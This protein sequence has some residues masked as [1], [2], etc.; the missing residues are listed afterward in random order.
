MQKKIFAVLLFLAATIFSFGS[1]VEKVRFNEYPPQMVFDLSEDAPVYS[2]DY[3]EYNRLLFLDIGNN[4]S[5]KDKN[6]RNGLPKYIEKVQ[7]VD[8]GTSSGYFVTLNKNIFHKVSL[9]KNPNR[10]V[11]D[12]SKNAQNKQYT[13]V[14]DP[15]HGGK[16]PGAIG[17]GGTKEKDIAL[18]VGKYLRDELKKDFNVVMTRDSDEF[19]TL[20]NR[21]KISNGIGADLFISVHINSAEN[22]KLSGMEIFYFS[23]K[24]SPYA[25]RIAEFENSVGA[26]Y[27]EDA[28]S[29][30]QIMGQIA[31][32]KN[33]E[34]SIKLAQGLNKDMSARMKM[35]DRGIHGA[36]FA[37]LRG[38][39]SPGILIEL[40]FIRNPEDHR[41]MT[42]RTNQKIMAQKIAEHVRKY[43]Y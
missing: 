34:K 14:I 30:V 18:A 20:T 21:S 24:S 25:E 29:I 15:G 40:G 13:V 23:K 38:I 7:R 3:D 26:K 17:I 22:S 4:S 42:N 36:N 11:V 16:D 37:V 6:T 1:V 43:F 8:Y 19:I 35:R 10:V 2:A 41:K 33:Q 9:R 39:N 32:N 27:G 12:F 5:A 31:Y 28:N